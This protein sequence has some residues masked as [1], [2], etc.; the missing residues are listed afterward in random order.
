MAVVNLNLAQLT[1]G[2]AQLRSGLGKVTVAG[3]YREQLFAI[4]TEA[5]SS[6]DGFS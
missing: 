6:E 4:A 3:G 1:A 5:A 2:P